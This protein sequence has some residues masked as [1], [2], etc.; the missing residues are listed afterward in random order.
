MPRGL[1]G[2]PAAQAQ[3]AHQGSNLEQPG[4]EPGALTA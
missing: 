3:W 1:G 4:Y 2:G